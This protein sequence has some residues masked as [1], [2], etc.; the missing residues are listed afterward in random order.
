MFIV[1]KDTRQS[2]FNTLSFTD[3]EEKEDVVSLVLIAVQEK[4]LFESTTKI[5]FSME[6]ACMATD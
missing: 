1:D 4:Y 2:P 5:K 6:S 3:Y